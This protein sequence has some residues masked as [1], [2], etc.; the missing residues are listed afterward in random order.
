MKREETWM[1]RTVKALLTRLE[2]G[3]RVT[4]KVTIKGTVGDGNE[5]IGVVGGTRYFAD[6]QGATRWL[7]RRG[8]APPSSS[9]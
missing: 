7:E 6:R 1:N 5:I 4:Y 8:Y 3:D 9:G 2:D